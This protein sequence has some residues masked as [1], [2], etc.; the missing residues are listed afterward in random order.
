MIFK[1]LYNDIK[2]YFKQTET[3]KFYKIFMKRYMK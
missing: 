1:K 3:Y 2:L